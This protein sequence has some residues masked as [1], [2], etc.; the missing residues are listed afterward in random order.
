MRYLVV[1]EFLLVDTSPSINDICKDKWYEQ[2]YYR[3]CMQREL[4]TATVGDG[5]RTLKISY[6]WIVS[7]IVPACA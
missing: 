6:R 5:E 2:R 4:A 7:R 3:H 1:I